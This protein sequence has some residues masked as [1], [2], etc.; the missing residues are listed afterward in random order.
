MYLS[1]YVVSNFN[2]DRYYAYLALLVH[3]YFQI[4]KEIL[5]AKVEFI[6]QISVQQFGLTNTGFQESEAKRKQGS[7][8]RAC[9]IKLS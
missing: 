6:R 3:T 1:F 7:A 8:A 2:I 4:Q 5:I 9:L